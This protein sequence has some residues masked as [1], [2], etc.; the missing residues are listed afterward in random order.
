[1]SAKKRI[2]IVFLGNPYHDSRVTNLYNSLLDDNFI[3]DVIS[4]DWFT[5][6][7]YKKSKY[8]IFK[9]TK[10]KGSLFFYLSFFFK[11]FFS[12]SNAKADIFFAEDIYTLPIVVFWAK[13]K[14]AKVFYNSREIYAFIGG[15]RNKPFI[16][17]II[18]LTEKYFIKKVE[19]VLTTGE[20]D[21][22]FIKN[23]YQINNVIT[24]RNIP[25]FQ[26]PKKNFDFREKYNIPKNIKILLYQGILIDGRGI[27]LIIKILSKINDVVFILLGEGSEKNKFI[28]LAKDYNVSDKVIFAGSFPQNELINY[29]ASAD[30]GLALIENISISYY[31]ALPNKLFEYIMANVPVI[32]SDLPQMKN[33]VER[34]NVGKVVNLENENDILNTITEMINHDELLIKYKENCKKASLELNWQKEY[35]ILQKEIINNL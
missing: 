8:K 31:H 24:V 17:K 21:T 15:L 29:T 12:L 9:L 4:F 35:L 32:S 23:F 3:V 30:I 28:Q 27:S 22:D 11:Q 10:S 14:K 33:I 18:T 7:D 34:Y 13:I 5:K 25:I 1:M 2:C 20:M 26:V 16:Q 6:L 19:L